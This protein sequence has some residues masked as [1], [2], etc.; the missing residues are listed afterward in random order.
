MYFKKH[1]EFT[2]AGVK[3]R[4]PQG[5]KGRIGSH[6]AKGQF[7]EPGLLAHVG[8]QNR[9]GTYV[10]AGMNNGN[11]ALYFAL[12]CPSRQ[13]IG[14]EPYG[15]WVRHA[16]ELFRMNKM[17][18]HIRIMN[19]ALGAA[20]GTI[21]LDINGKWTESPVMRLDDL[22]LTDVAVMKIDVEGM[23]RAVLQ[24]A[25][26]TIRSQKPLLYIEIF[27]DVLDETT[28]YL[29]GLG[30]DRGRRFGSPTYLFAPR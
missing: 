27:D 16:H 10:D 17:T 26:A 5:I 28:A 18:E 23:E 13:V 24:G 8:A 30:Y 14:F 6:W 29:D 25:E 1:A 4:L 15:E 7:Y 3:V 19:C 22:G 11:H 21:D 9:P 2:I 20:P 12:C